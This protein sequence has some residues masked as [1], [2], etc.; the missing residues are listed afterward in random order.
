MR[1][2]RDETEWIQYTDVRNASDDEQ[3]WDTAWWYV[4]LVLHLYSHILCVDLSIRW[5]ATLCS[6]YSFW[7]RSLLTKTFALHWH[8]WSSKLNDRPREC[9]PQKNWWQMGYQ[10]DCSITPVYTY[11]G[12]SWALL[13]N[14]HSLTAA[15]SSSFF[16]YLVQSVFVQKSTHA[17]PH[18]EHIRLQRWC[19]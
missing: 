3:P 19:W 17:N 16:N 10:L 1:W 2:L 11:H 14:T 8:G 13:G 9:H 15:E 7:V 4:N 12:A 18:P 5:Y 6:H